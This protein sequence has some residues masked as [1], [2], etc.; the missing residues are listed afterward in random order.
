MSGI[1]IFKCFNKFAFSIYHQPHL[2]QSTADGRRG[3]ERR[4]AEQIRAARGAQ[5]HV[6]S[7]SLVTLIAYLRSYNPLHIFH[8]VFS[9]SRHLAAAAAAERLLFSPLLLS[10]S[11]SVAPHL[12]GS[13]RN[14]YSSHSPRFYLLTHH[15][16]SSS[17]TGNSRDRRSRTRTHET[18]EADRELRE[19]ET[20]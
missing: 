18:E 16:L 3:G 14:P 9:F 5:A 13:D 1:N 15:D 2:R 19:G 8:C 7:T 4:A 17:R 10:L 6:K 12:A 11:V 20:D